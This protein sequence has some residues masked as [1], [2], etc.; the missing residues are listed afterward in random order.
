MAPGYNSTTSIIG[1]FDY[2]NYNG[3]YDP[4]MYGS[5]MDFEMAYFVVNH[6]GYLYAETA[7]TYTAEATTA[8][9]MVFV[10]VGGNAYSGWGRWNKNFQ[11]AFYI[12][13]GSGSASF[14]M[15]AGSY[16]P[17]RIV[18]VQAQGSARF[19]SE[20]IGQDRTVTLNSETT[21]SPYIVQYGCSAEDAPRHQS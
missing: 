16:M 8:D 21:P 19:D 9:D 14:N 18:Y 6:R 5:S 11:T 20:L 13:P 4:T 12:S 7:D 10:W 15:T 2:G 1:G 17:L 3:T